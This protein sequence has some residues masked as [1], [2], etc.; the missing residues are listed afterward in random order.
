MRS[1]Y[2]Y[3]SLYDRYTASS[4]K[5]TLLTKVFT[6]ET[7]ALYAVNEIVV[8]ATIAHNRSSKDIYEICHHIYE[9][10]LADL[11]SHFILNLSPWMILIISH[12][13][14]KLSLNYHTF[15]ANRATFFI[16]KPFINTCVMI[17]MTALLNLFESMLCCEIFNAYWT[18]WLFSHAW[19]P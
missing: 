10:F 7:Y 13:F 12:I 19:S 5:E 17:L 1:L 9:D 2:E 8:M 3:E 16:L 14:N 15:V 6:I 18:I 11:S 4:R